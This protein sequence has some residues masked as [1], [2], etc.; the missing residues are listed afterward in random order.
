[1]LMF[2]IKSRLSN[3]VYVYEDIDKLFYYLIKKGEKSTV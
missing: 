3:P 1:M 2:A